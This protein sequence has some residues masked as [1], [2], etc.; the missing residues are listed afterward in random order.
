MTNPPVSHIS[1]KFAN[2]AWADNSN[3]MSYYVNAYSDGVKKKPRGWREWGRKR[4]QYSWPVERSLNTDLENDASI[5]YKK[6]CNYRELT[7][8]ERLVWSQFLLSQLIRTPTFMRY[9]EKACELFNIADKPEHD[10]VG[11]P[12]C[13][14]LIYVVNR[15]WCLLLA[16]EDDHFVRSDN[17]V[18]QTGFIELPDS[19]LFYPLTPKLCFVA[20]SMPKDWNAFTDTPNDTI[21]RQLVKGGAQAINFHLGKS[22]GES[23][24]VS[25]QHDGVVVETMNTDILG[26]YPQPPFPLHI[27]DG[28]D[29]ED[30]FDSIR[31]IMSITDGFEYPK[32]Q[33]ME[34]EP[35]FQ[36]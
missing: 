14:D 22:A 27:I 8:G 15:D 19:C 35:F 17:P 25:P 12:E 1:P 3:Y 18:F 28:E 21:G 7:A 20:C 11:C 34:L 10:R 31:R 16:H 24:I 23:L 33:P 13:S 29:P 30:A 9:E 6:I 32:W 4:G 26:V 5:I 36:R 2:K